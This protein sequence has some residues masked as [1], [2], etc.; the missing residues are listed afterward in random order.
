MKPKTRTEAKAVANGGEES[1]V[2][3]RAIS[4]TEE[5]K[6]SYGRRREGNVKS[7]PESSSF[8]KR[9]GETTPNQN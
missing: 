5:I 4:E 6:L 1:G 9:L 7:D 8:S 2:K 3:P